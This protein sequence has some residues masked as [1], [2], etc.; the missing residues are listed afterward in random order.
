MSLCVYNNV[1]VQVTMVMVDFAL[2]LV[3]PPLHAP[4][5]QRLMDLIKVSVRPSSSSML[6]FSFGNL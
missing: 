5:H 6:I 3:T 4:T 1:T 2:R